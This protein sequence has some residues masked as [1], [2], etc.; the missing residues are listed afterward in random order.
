MSD[1]ISLSTY[2]R[3][4]ELESYREFLIEKEKIQD[5][6]PSKPWGYT[7][8]ENHTNKK[9]EFDIEW[10]NDYQAYKKDMFDLMNRY[11]SPFQQFI[12]DITSSRDEIKA[13][14]FIRGRKK[15]KIEY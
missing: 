2:D 9:G 5:K 3:W 8:V 15:G 6:Y 7:G 13:E 12:W 14:R 1:N 11:D 10:W 4:I